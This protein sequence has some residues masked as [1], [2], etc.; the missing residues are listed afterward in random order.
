VRQSLWALLEE[1]EEDEYDLASL[2]LLISRHVGEDVSFLEFEPASPRLARDALHGSCVVPE[3]AAW[4]QKQLPVWAHFDE[5]AF[6]A[7]FGEQLVQALCAY[8]DVSR[9]PW[10]AT[11]GSIHNADAK[12]LLAW[13]RGTT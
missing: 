8:I 9:A 11:G 4:F 13:M 12:A 1:V 10:M 2:D 6:C 7:A 5:A 3:L